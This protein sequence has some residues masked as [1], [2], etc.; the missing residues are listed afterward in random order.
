MIKEKLS[1][2]YSRGVPL[3]N[4]WMAL[5]FF[6]KMKLHQVSFT[7]PWSIM[8]LACLV[9]SFLTDMEMNMMFVTRHFRG[10]WM[11]AYLSTILQ[12]S[13]TLFFST[14]DT[15]TVF[16]LF[17]L[18]LAL[19]IYFFCQ[20][21]SPGKVHGSKW[22]E[23]KELLNRRF[24]MSAL[25]VAPSVA[26]LSGKVLGYSNLTG[27]G[28]HTTAVSPECFLLYSAVSGLLVVLFCTVPPSLSTTRGAR[29]MA[30][31]YIPSIAY[32][33]LFFL[34]MA[35]VVAAQKILQEYVYL[36]C[37]P[38]AILAP[39]LCFCDAQAAG[40]SGLPTTTAA[41]RSPNDERQDE[42]KLSKYLFT[43]GIS[44][45]LLAVM[46]IHSSYGAIGTVSLSW[47]WKA[48]VGLAVCSI[49]SH[50]VHILILDQMTDIKRYEISRKFW[51][52]G[53]CAAITITAVSAVLVICL[54]PDEVKN[55]FWDLFCFVSWSSNK[56]YHGH[57][58]CLMNADQ[59]S[60]MDPRTTLFIVNIYL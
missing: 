45:I 28:G 58:S 33:A 42:A 44:P 52:A 41:Q 51:T 37:C 32:V 14:T 34:V 30:K 48:F 17:G 25:V 54:H 5:S 53:T 9:L 35:T 56:T 55:I 2:F 40:S 15:M 43:V 26:G 3:V 24:E 59:G 10:Q 27:G 38:F 4:V 60:C 47:S 16:F 21:F 7:S 50:T 49:L 18:V 8:Y 31:V 20:M 6:V 36:L 12:I 11:V 46:A 22:L 1:A 19:V 29:R 57:R 13:V 23:F 39:L